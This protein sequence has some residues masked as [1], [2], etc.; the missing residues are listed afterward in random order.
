M[1]LKDWIISSCIGIGFGVFVSAM[2]T[3]CN[4]ERTA[5]Q[6]QH[7]ILEQQAKAQEKG[8]TLQLKGKDG[9]RKVEELV[10]DLDNTDNKED[11]EAIKKQIVDEL[12]NAL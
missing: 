10:K 8:V 7:K 5:H 1:T 4:N 3:R 6:Q 12:L 9:R 2:L 11:K